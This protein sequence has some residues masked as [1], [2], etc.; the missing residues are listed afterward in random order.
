MLKCENAH[1]SRDFDGSYISVPCGDFATFAVGLTYED[2]T[3][4]PSQ[5]VAVVL[6]V[7]ESCK[8]LITAPSANKSADHPDRV[9][10]VYVHELG[11]SGSSDESGESDNALIQTG[12]ITSCTFSGGYGNPVYRRKD[13]VLLA[14][15]NYHGE[16]M[17]HVLEPSDIDD[18]PHIQVNTVNSDITGNAAKADIADMMGKTEYPVKP[19]IEDQ[20]NCWCESSACDNHHQ[21]ARC[22]AN[23]DEASPFMV[24]VGRVCEACATRIEQADGAIFIIR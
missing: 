7:C 24:Y 6:Y 8:N 5:M 14:V 11:N 10:V 23:V 18:T 3:A 12:F 19:P 13:G 15:D 1:D 17:L 16:D 22:P 21:M 2:T 20:R 4:V 9:I